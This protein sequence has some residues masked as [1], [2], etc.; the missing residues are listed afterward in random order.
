M[1]TTAT[2]RGDDS[3]NKSARFTHF[4]ARRNERNDES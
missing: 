3:D 1:N 4:L 2:E